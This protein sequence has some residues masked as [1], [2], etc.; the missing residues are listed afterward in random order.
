MFLTNE[1]ITAVVEDT[2]IFLSESRIS[3]Q[4]TIQICLSVEEV[5]LE[6]QKHLGEQTQFELHRKKQFGCTYVVLQVEGE[7][8]NLLEER[9]EEIPLFFLMDKIDTMPSWQYRRGRN[10]VRFSAYTGKRNLSLQLIIA[11][12]IVGMLAGVRCRRLPES[13]IAVICDSYLSPVSS[14]ILGLLSSLSTVMIFVS[15]VAGISSMGDISTFN[16]IGRR[17]L[18][19]FL[20]LMF[21]GLIMCVFM[22]MTVFPIGRG[23][24]ARFDFATLWQMIVNI[25]PTNIF[26][27]FLDGNALQVVFLAIFSGIIMLTLS[28]QTANIL[29]L[30]TAANVI[31]QRTLLIVIKTMPIVVFISMFKLTVNSSLSQFISIWRYPVLVAAS[32]LLFLAAFALRT[33][34]TQHV[35]FGILLRKLFP[36]FLIGVTTAS[37]SAAFATNMDT[38]VKALG[39]DRRFASIGVPLGQTLFKPTMIFAMVC[40][41]FCLAELYQVPI[42][43]SMLLMMVFSVFIL[44]MAA[45][46]IP[47]G[48]ISCFSVLFA[49]LGIPLEAVSIIIALDVLVDRIRTSAVLSLTQMELVQQAA[50]IGQLDKKTLQSAED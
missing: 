9:D 46:P 25:V 41:S 39:I 42:T 33:C 43:P 22:C 29:D 45:P 23:G 20:L 27:P 28:T 31:I 49:Q 12:V 1:S 50:E 37:S 18:L 4:R 35:Q 34:L 17:M 16:R 13:V 21:L 11:T 40:G 36:T 24:S 2:R 44:A 6:Y 7:Q 14:M 3:K 19:R 26:A 30:N 47:G 8:L 15:T 5:L 32:C 38:C 10:I 48:A